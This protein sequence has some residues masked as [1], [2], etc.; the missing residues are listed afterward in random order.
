M[1]DNLVIISNIIITSILC[2]I[3]AYVHIYVMV[4]AFE[5]KLKYL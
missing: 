1:L 2:K 5:F 4:E 3:Y